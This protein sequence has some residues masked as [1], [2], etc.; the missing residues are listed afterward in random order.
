MNEKLRKRRGWKIGGKATAGKIEMILKER[1]YRKEHS[2]PKGV[3]PLFH[4]R[5]G[6]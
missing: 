3:R 1:N 6:G 4:R 5:V 2:D